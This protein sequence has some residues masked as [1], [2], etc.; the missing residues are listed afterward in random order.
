MRV[1]GQ[2]LDM[3]AGVGYEVRR[4]VIPKPLKKRLHSNFLGPLMRVGLPLIKN[5]LTP[6]AKSVLSRL[7][8]VASVTDTFIQ[9]KIFESEMTTL[10][11][12]NEEMNDTV[13]I[14]KS[15]EESSLLIKGV[16][17]TIKNESEKWKGGLL[18]ILL[19]VLSADLLRNMLASK[20]VIQAD[21][22]TIKAG[23]DF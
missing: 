4:L 14:V 20:R 21:E 17:G 9:K 19:A 22:R 10:M 3:R 2:G 5:V 18:S 6:L 12:S 23:Q 1:G 8:A 16:N 15:L 7:T 11:I 13:K